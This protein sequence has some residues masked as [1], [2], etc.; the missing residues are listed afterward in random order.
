ME[1]LSS[2]RAKTLLL[3]ACACAL[4]FAL[5]TLTSDE[6]APLSNAQSSSPECNDGIDNDNDGDGDDVLHHF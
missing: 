4:I 2:A 1:I 6:A 5:H 3:L